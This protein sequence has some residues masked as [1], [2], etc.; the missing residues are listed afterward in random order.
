[1]GDLFERPNKTMIDKHFARIAV[2]LGRKN[3]RLRQ[4]GYMT[5]T[6]SAIEIHG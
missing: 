6:A 4:R 3:I 5:T 2:F 1:L